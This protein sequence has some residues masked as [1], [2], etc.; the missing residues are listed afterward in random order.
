MEILKLIK[1]TASHL[2]LHNDVLNFRHRE[3]EDISAIEFSC[4]RLELDLKKDFF[5]NDNYLNYFLSVDEKTRI[6]V[7]KVTQ[8]YLGIDIINHMHKS[9]IAAA[10]FMHHRLMFSIY[11]KLIVALA[12]EKH[13][14]LGLL[15]GRAI[16]NAAE[17]IKWRFY[18]RQHAPGNVWLQICNLFDM[19]E[20]NGSVNEKMRLYPE[21]ANAEFMPSSIASA[22][23]TINMLGSLDHAAFRP[24]QIDFLSKILAKWTTDLTVEKEYNDKKH[25]FSVDLAKNLPAK[26]IRNFH[27][28]ITNRY[29]CMDSVNVKLQI[30]MNCIETNRPPKQKPMRT[31]AN[32]LFAYPTLVAIKSEWSLSDYKRQRRESPR[33]KTDKPATDVYGF[34]DT[35]YQIKHYEDTLVEVSKKSFSEDLGEI[36]PFEDD[37][38]SAS[39]AANRLRQY[40]ESLTTYIDATKGQCHIVD[41]SVKGICI[42]TSRHAQELSVGMMLGVA[43]KNQKVGTRIGIIRSIKPTQ[44]NMLRIGVEILSRTAFSI[45]A[46]NLK[47]LPSKPVYGYVVE[48]IEE[49]VE[50]ND[51]EVVNLNENNG[52]FDCL[53][54]PKEFSFTKEESLILP[55][56]QFEKNQQYLLDLGNK[57]RTVVLTD[58]LEQHDNWVRSYFKDIEN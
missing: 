20:K 44:N 4:Q 1:N 25:L 28:I 11:F 16:N 2:P 56:K 29:W 14:Q 10:C 52:K 23:I 55:K 21:L 19:A 37:E 6:L 48:F 30:L 22:F 36:S 38:D 31:L 40:V 33:I 45:E 50:T 58:T 17:I 39:I 26:R 34:E 47:M 35:Y 49:N 57:E 15:I 53:F 12:P 5:H 9:R 43:A 27:H 51:L 13:P 32:H 41:E 24:A 54:L 18:N 42:H 3:S 8:S 46:T 7:E